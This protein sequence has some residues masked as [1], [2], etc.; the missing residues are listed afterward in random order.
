MEGIVIRGKVDGKSGGVYFLVKH[1]DARVNDIVNKMS[2]KIDDNVDDF[3]SVLDNNEVF[4][5]STPTNKDEFVSEDVNDIGVIDDYFADEIFTI[6]KFPIKGK[7]SAP[8]SAERDVEEPVTYILH[9][10]ADNEKINEHVVNHVKRFKMSIE[11]NNIPKNTPYVP[12]HFQE[13]TVKGNFVYSRRVTL[14]KLLL[15]H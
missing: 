2:N 4:T 15:K 12:F 3:V 5:K 13:S 7:K 9:D 8:S 11:K 6:K 10:I 1:K 14:D